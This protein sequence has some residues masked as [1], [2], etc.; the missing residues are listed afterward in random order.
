MVYPVRSTAFFVTFLHP[1][2]D[3]YASYQIKE[4]TPSRCEFVLNVLLNS[5]PIDTK[6]NNVLL[7]ILRFHIRTSVVSKR[8]QKLTHLSIHHRPF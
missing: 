8:T 2:H 6:K 1:R 5:L 4:M 3:V 7:Y